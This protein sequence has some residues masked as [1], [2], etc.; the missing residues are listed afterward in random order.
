MKTLIAGDLHLKQPVVLPRI[1]KLLAAD[2]SIGRV[3]FLGDACDDWNATPRSALHALEFYADWV[4]RKRAAGLQIDVLLG[5]HDF[6]YIRGKRGPG[7]IMTIMRDV[8]K[9]LENELR[10][11]VACAVGPCLCTH[12]GVT[13]VW[14]AK[15]LA[16]VLPDENNGV[17]IEQLAQALNDM[18]ADGE[19]WA[20]LDSCPPSRGGWQLPGPLWADLRDTAADPL[21]GVSQIVGHT[22]VVTAHEVC[23]SQHVNAALWACDTFSLTSTGFPIGDGSMLLVNANNQVTRLEFPGNA[24]GFRKAATAYLAAQS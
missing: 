23:L 3:V 17:R 10:V 16:N 4:E 8:R 13:G 11:Q 6:C 7:T 18:L 12:A 5:N 9:L 1:D 21:A 22:P 15:H 20:A 2:A 19:C 14:A 24:A